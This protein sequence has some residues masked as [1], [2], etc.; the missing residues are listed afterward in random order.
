MKKKSA[1]Y[2]KCNY[3]KSNYD[4]SSEKTLLL[5]ENK[6]Y[7]CIKELKSLLNKSLS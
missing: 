7:V 2:D 3:N 6:H 1:N 4:R 5:L